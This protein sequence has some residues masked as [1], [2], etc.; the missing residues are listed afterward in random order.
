MEIKKV[1]NNN[2]Y[3]KLEDILL[4]HILDNYIKKLY[5]Y[6]KVDLATSKDKEVA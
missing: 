4:E 1:Y 3:L 2:S 5:N 6:C